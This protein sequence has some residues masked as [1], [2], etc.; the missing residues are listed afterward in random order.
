MGSRK[1]ALNH[2]SDGVI[3]LLFEPI[4]TV[5]PILAFSEYILTVLNY[6]LNVLWVS[7][8]LKLLNFFPTK[9]LFGTPRLLYIYIYHYKYITLLCNGFK[10]P[11][12]KQPLV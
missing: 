9:L 7:L 4:Y 5:A 2:K 1:N 12:I 6:L 11:Y 10:V 3:H 8:I